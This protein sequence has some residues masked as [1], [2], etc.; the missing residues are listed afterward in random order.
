MYKYSPKF[1]NVVSY[2]QHP[3]HF[4]NNWITRHSRKN[5]FC[6]AAGRLVDRQE[7]VSPEYFVSF[8]ADQC[9]YLNNK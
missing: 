7:L 2:D 4:K 9:V 8:V 5:V 1:K 6:W 3:S